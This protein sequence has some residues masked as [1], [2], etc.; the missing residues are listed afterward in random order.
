[1]CMVEYIW[2]SYVVALCCGS[3]S[4][5]W[6]AQLQQILNVACLLHALSC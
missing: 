6:K 1:M 3:Q 5:W 2:A 4:K